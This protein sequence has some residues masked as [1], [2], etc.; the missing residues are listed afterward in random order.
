MVSVP[1]MLVGTGVGDA[2]GLGLEMQDRK[3]IAL[4]TFDQW[5]N[6]RTGKHGMNY[7]PGMYSDDTE[8]TIGVVKALL[9]E[10]VFSEELLLAFWKN[11]YES[12]IKNRGFPR[13]GH[14]SIEGYYKG[15]VTISEIRASQAGRVHPGNAPVMRANVLG[16]LPENTL[17]EYSKIN[18]DS[19][20]PHPEAR[21]G[22]DLVAYAAY[23]LLN[24]GNPS[25]IFHHFATKAEFDSIKG[26]LSKLDTLPILEDI[27]SSEFELLCGPQP[28]K[29]AGGLIEG[30][31]IS[32]IHT[33]LASVYILKYSSDAF[34]GLQRA[35]QMGGDVD[36]LA[37]VTVGILAGRYGLESIPDFILDNL[38]GRE[39]LDELGTRFAHYLSGAL[40]R[41]E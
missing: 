6:L 39:M 40:P 9:S 30:V 37:A 2:Y 32:A 5:H 21:L 3:K 25:E 26:L 11:E 4:L 23:Y 10:E 27:S 18:A 36:S 41:F 15:T 13:Q 1:E 24:G 22:S 14:G 33:A 31:P 35:L 19:T 28:I 17:F 8:H 7:A 16:L 29:G 38:E 34:T 12:D 20:H